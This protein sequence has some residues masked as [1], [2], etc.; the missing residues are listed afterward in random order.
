MAQA[1]TKQT[2]NVV[3]IDGARKIPS[4]NPATGMRL[5]AEGF[6][7]RDWL[8][9]LPPDAIFDDVGNHT[10]ELFQ[11]VQGSPQHSLRT[12]DRLRIR[13]HDRSWEAWATVVFADGDNAILSRPRKDD[14]AEANQYWGDEKVETFW[15]GYGYSIQRK[16]DNVRML[17]GSYATAEAARI[18]WFQSQPK[19]V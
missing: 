9:V 16:A 18:A 19:R 14:L 6:Q 3:P 7:W 12:D 8:V 10:K 13:A 4:I 11:R 2:D 17:P 15:D 5:N 1:A